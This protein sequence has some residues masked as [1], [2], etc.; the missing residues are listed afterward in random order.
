MFRGP[1][2]LVALGA[3]DQHSQVQLFMEGPFDKTITFIRVLETRDMLAIPRDVRRETGD[4]T[5]PEASFAYLAGHTLGKLLDE[6]F[7]AT[8]EALRSMGRMSATW[9]IS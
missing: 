5:A 3:T 6:E 7:M 2:P 1:T 9:S 4:V 8:R